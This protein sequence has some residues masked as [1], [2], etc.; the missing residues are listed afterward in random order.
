VAGQGIT[1][2]SA[3]VAV[4]SNAHGLQ[5]STGTNNVSV[6]Y[7]A[8]ANMTSAYQNTLVGGG[9]TG[10]YSGAGSSISTGYSNAFFGHYAGGLV[11]TGYKNTIIGGYSGNQGGLDIR[12]SSNYIVLSDGDG[13]PRGIFDGSGN[14]FVGT[15]GSLS[16]VTRQTVVATT[17]GIAASFQSPTAGNQTID[18]WNYGASG[19]RYFMQFNTE[20]TSTA[21]GYLTYNGT[22]VAIAQASDVRLKENI[23]DAP[24]ALPKIS[25]MQIRSF[26]FKE[27]GRHVDYGVVAQELHDVVPDAVFIGQD[28]KDGSIDK[29]W[30]VGLEPVIPMLVKAI[31]ELSAELNALKQKVGA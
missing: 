19:T 16:S 28:K 23:V 31:Q 1:T 27:D 13:N 29:P 3:N 12:T 30:S 25:A 4:G 26:D 6:G 7:G 17:S 24:S 18:V 9:V 8:G 2:G 21:R 5:Y 14:F 15:T 22:T 11:T 20:A 10:F